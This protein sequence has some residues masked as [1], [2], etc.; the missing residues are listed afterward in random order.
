MNLGYNNQISLLFMSIF[1]SRNLPGTMWPIKVPIISLN[2]QVCCLFLPLSW[3]DRIEIHKSFAFRKQQTEEQNCGFQLFAISN[4]IR[5]WSKPMQI[6]SVIFYVQTHK[7]SCVVSLLNK[8]VWLLRQ[9]FSKYQ[10]FVG[11]FLYR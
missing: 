4:N 7:F 11:A 8:K 3:I 5:F 6:N 1:H 2:F 10:T 9:P